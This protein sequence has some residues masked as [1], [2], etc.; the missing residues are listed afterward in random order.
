[1]KLDWDLRFVGHRLSLSTYVAER[2]AA[3]AAGRLIL[4]LNTSLVA[5]TSPVSKWYLVL[6]DEKS[7]SPT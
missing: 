1:V 7:L 2:Q 4:F 6:Q 5:L 3:S